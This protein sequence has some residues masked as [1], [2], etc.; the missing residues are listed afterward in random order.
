MIWFQREGI[1]VMFHL[2]AMRC[3]EMMQK[4]LNHLL[5]HCPIALSLFEKV[6]LGG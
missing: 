3:V 1:I 2:I 5:L 4:G 6:V